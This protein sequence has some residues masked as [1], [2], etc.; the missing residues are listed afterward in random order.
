[1]RIAIYYRVSTADQT[2]DPQRLELLEYCRRQGWQ[3]PKEFSDTISG[4]KWDRV[5]LDMLMK[6]VR[7][8]RFDA[9]LCVKLDRLGRSLAHLAQLVGELTSHGVA[10]IAT[11]QGIDT[12]GS[13]SAGRFQLHVLMAVAEFEREIIRERTKAGLA[14]AIANGKKLGR[15]RFILTDDHMAVLEKSDSMTIAEVARALGC[16]T[17]KAHQLVR[18]REDGKL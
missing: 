12:R 8:G 14:N 16:S 4:S 2:T 3:D 11:S 7:A 9:V 15:P 6:G 5:G 13:N 18:A 17:T 1:M 10:I